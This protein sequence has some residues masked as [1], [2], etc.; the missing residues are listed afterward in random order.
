MAI[1]LIRWRQAKKYEPTTAEHRF[2]VYVVY[3]VGGLCARL[4]SPSWV[5][6]RKK[7]KRS[8]STLFFRD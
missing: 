6:K 8:P 7:K 4:S 1:V 5:S 3:I 2:R